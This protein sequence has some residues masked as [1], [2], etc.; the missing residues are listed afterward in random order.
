MKAPIKAIVES[1][2]FEASLIFVSSLLSRLIKLNLCFILILDAVF[3]LLR[4]V[5]AMA[6]SSE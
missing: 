5:S 3:I 6:T 1:F 2:I 4:D